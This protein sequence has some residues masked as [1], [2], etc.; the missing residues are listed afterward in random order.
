MY[1]KSLE[2][3]ENFISSRFHLGL[4]YHRT[5][6]FHQALKCFSNVLQR[7]PDD[8]T[9]YIARGLVY[10]DMG[11]HQFA[12]DDFNKAI[13]LKNNFSEAFYRRGISKLKMRQYPDGIDDF[14]QAYDLLY[15]AADDEEQKVEGEDGT[16]GI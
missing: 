15:S 6:K 12:V 8:K 11:N 16:S 4:M 9:V 10:Q 2:L 3:S 13:E 1:N 7:L 14:K 5:N